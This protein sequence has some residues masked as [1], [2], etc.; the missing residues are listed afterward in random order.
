MASPRHE[1]KTIEHLG[2]VA[3]M[4]DELGITERIDA[5]VTQDKE[6]R[7]VSVG[8]AVKAMIFNGL[9]FTNRRLYLTSHF[10]LNKPTERLI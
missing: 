3:G 1:T 9:G 8:Q 5:L 7:H 6:Q 10:F 2:L 4:V